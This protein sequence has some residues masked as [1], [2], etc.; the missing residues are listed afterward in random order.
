M[1]VQY[2][3]IKTSQLSI[4]TTKSILKTSWEGNTQ[5]IN[6][7]IKLQNMKQNVYN[8]KKVKINVSHLS[9]TEHLYDRSPSVPQFV[10]LPE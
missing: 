10:C 9:F 3:I 5:Q 2:S 6:N 1:P 7:A 4:S 8:T